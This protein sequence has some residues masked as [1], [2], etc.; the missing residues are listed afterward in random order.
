MVSEQSALTIQLQPGA[1][2]GAEDVAVMAR[3]LRAELLELDVENV[4]LAGTGEAPAGAKGIGLLAI[5]GLVVRFGLQTE[6]LRTVVTG[7]QSWLGRQRL[8][9]VKL[10]LDGDSIEVTGA[11]SAEQAHLIDAFIAR[12][13]SPE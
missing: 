4:E 11:S 10:V 9:S 13:A 3:R 1:D 8:H 12:H 6:I 5:G 2:A 7:V